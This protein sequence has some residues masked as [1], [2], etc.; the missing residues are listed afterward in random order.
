MLW[1]NSRKHTEKNLYSSKLF[2]FIHNYK[3]IYS[4]WGLTPFYL[5]GFSTEILIQ[6][7]KQRRK[8]E[9]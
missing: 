1:E 4:I 3:S 7:L 6:R 8:A 5:I 9:V 2:Y